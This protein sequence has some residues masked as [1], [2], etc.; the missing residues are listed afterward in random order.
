M[1]VMR[2]ERMPMKGGPEAALSQDDL[3]KFKAEADKENVNFWKERI[4]SAS[5]LPAYEDF[6]KSKDAAREFYKGKFFTQKEIDAWDGDSVQANLF[7]RLVNFMIDS[8]YAED[9]RISVGSRRKSLSP[10]VPSSAMSAPNGALGGAMPPPGAPPM[11]MGGAPPPPPGKIDPKAFD[12]LKD[13]LEYIFEEEQL[14]TEIKKIL[15]DAFF[16]NIASAKI[17]FDK[18]RGIFRAKHVCGLLVLDPDARGDIS[19]ARWKAEQVVMPRYRVWQEKMFDPKA[20]AEI[21][22]RSS[23]QI[24]YSSNQTTAETLLHKVENKDCEVLWFI[25]TKEGISPTK[26]GVNAEEDQQKMDG[27]SK[28]RLL[29]IA[30][31]YDGWLAN[32]D[33]PTP[34]LDDDEFSYETIKWDEMPGEWLGVAPWELIKSIVGSYSWACSYHMSDMRMTAMRTLAYDKNKVDDPNAALKSRKHQTMVGVDGTPKD[35]VLPLD[36]G[37]ADKT[38]FDSVGFFSNLLDKVTGV[39]EIARGEEGRTKTATESQILQQNSNIVLRGPSAN[40]DNFLNNLVRKLALATLYYM[41]AF[42]IVPNPMLNPLDPMMPGM[43][44]P[45]KLLTRQPVQMPMMDPMTGMPAIDPMG[46]P[47]MQQQIVTVPAPPE[48]QEPMKGIDYFHGDEAATIWSTVKAIPHEE[49]R[50]ELQFKVEAGSTRAEKRLEKKQEA[51]ELLNTWGTELKTL[52]LHNQMW[53]LWDQYLNA[54]QIDK[55]KILP[56]KE[57]YMMRSQQ[58][59]MLQMQ[60]AALGAETGGA[61]KGNSGAFQQDESGSAK[62]GTDF[63]MSGSTKD[64]SSGT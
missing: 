11:P 61:G 9:P 15:K 7:P 22:Q 48:F 12:I 32:I 59:Q 18:Q 38:I 6:K 40:L 42:S 45:P 58:M 21:K 51:T 24:S 46:Q 2:P 39:D 31:N 49:L 10:I 19:R 23:K 60:N 63:P 56:P 37:Q 36:K 47:I 1:S 50:C 44:S 53:E 17:D 33:D 28:S 35:C 26:Y 41:P 5:T 14:R 43:A 27:G 20:R 16:G 8:V 29:V 3:A 52:G 25:Y 62:K 34:F 64:Q 57:Q 13:H 30:E 54:F 4:K 55:S